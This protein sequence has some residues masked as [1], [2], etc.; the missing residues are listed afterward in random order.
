MS[1]TKEEILKRLAECRAEYKNVTT[2]EE[3]GLLMEN[4]MVALQDL[5]FLEKV[6][7]EKKNTIKEE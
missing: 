4:T 5:L 6:E 2:E 3:I 1:E 7:W